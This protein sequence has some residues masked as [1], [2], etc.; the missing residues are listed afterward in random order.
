MDSKTS[1]PDAKA[2]DS[3]V[4]TETEFAKLAEEGTKADDILFSEETKKAIE[5]YGE[6]V[7]EMKTTGCIDSYIMAKVTL[8][9]LIALIKQ[10]AMHHCF[11]IWNSEVGESYYGIGIYALENGQAS[12]D[13]IISFQLVRAYLHSRAVHSESDCKETVDAILEPC[14][15]YA[16]S[17]KPSLMPLLLGNW[18]GIYINIKGEYLPSSW[19]DPIMD[20]A[21]QNKIENIET[22]G[23]NFPHLDNWSTDWAGDSGDIEHFSPSGKQLGSS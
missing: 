3:R 5:C 23:I 21:K 14:F 1:K 17:K 8:G 4:L 11:D 6:I 13:D 22:L 18:F 7:R 19:V 20:R 16:Q 2:Q 10:D 15:K 9:T 12:N